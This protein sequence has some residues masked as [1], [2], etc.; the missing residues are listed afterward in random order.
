MKKISLLFCLVLIFIAAEAFCQDYNRIIS[1]SPNITEILYSLNAEDRLA[2]VTDY[3]DT[4]GEEKE[5]AQ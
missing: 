3:C 5:S 1:I 4:R 2:G